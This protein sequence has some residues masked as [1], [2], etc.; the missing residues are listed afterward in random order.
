MKDFNIWPFLRLNYYIFYVWPANLGKTLQYH[1][2]TN[3]IKFKT[4]SLV[5]EWDRKQCE[6]AWLVT[7]QMCRNLHLFLNKL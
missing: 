3:E 6:N 4:F 5:I 2:N 7:N 1:N